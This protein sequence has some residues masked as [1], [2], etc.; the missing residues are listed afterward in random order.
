MRRFSVVVFAITVVSA[1]LFGSHYYIATRLIIEPGVPDPWRGLLLASL[2]LAA[3]SLVASPVS[4]RTLSPALSRWIAWPASIWM[5]LWF[6][7]IL[8]T[9]I[10]D[11]GLLLLGALGV[12][13][14]GPISG[15][16][17]AAVVSISV[18]AGVLAIRSGL[19]PPRDVRVEIELAGWPSALDGFRIVQIT[20]IHIGLILDRRFA[21][22]IVDRV[23]ALQPD[24]IAVT[25]D[26]VD[27][28]VE[29]LA[30]DVA[31]FR[32]LKS[33]YGVYFVTGNH[34]YYS[35]VDDWVAKVSELG[36]RVL[37]NERVEIGDSAA[38]FDLIGVD[39]HRGNMIADDGKEDL[40]KALA[41]RDSTRSAI[42]LAH[43]PSTFRR[44][45]KMGIDLQ[46]SGHTHGG[47]IWPFGYIVRV[48]IPYV[49]GHYRVNESQ[50]YVS[51]GTGFWGPPMRL[52]APAEI[53]ELVIKGP[54]HV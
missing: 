19:S 44:A 9:A 36:M 28:G 25:G 52:F 53:T 54:V 7:L 8:A 47:Q 6:W 34:D 40:T 1:V 15:F 50:L 17:A 35:G 21:R 3:A 5:G 16:R 22:A 46:I 20:D 43:D 27:G 18:L 4:E 2:V 39:D 23:N 31:P 32:D 14:D 33:R 38:G 49:A 45:S 10:T 30:D 42:L 11:L 37:R 24:L 41:D 26:L 48:A 29:Q 12:A 13:D 51:R